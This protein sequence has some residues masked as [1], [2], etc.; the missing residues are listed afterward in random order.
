M[1]FLELKEAVLRVL[2]GG[3]AARYSFNLL[4]WYKVQILTPEEGCAAC[5]VGGGNAARYSFNLA[6]MVQKHKY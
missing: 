2:L 4:Y 5:A 6:L 3:D 1:G